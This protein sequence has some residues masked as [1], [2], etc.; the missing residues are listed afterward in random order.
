MD[1]TPSSVPCGRGR[2]REETRGR[3]EGAGP[4]TPLRRPGRARPRGHREREERRARVA[5]A[6]AAGTRGAGLLGAGASSRGTALGVTCWPLPAREEN[7]VAVR[8][9]PEPGLGAVA[10]SPALQRGWG[11]FLHAGAEARTPD[12]R[13]FLLR[14]PPGPGGRR[15]GRCSRGGAGRGACGRGR[16]RGFLW[17]GQLPEGRGRR[18]VP[19]GWAG[20][21]RWATWTR[22]SWRSARWK[23][24]SWVGPAEAPPTRAASLLRRAA[25]DSALQ[26]PSPGADFS[27]L[28]GRH[29]GRPA[30]FWKPCQRQRRVREATS[31][32]V[33]AEEV[34]QLITNLKRG[35]R[36]R[37][38]LTDQG[39]EVRIDAEKSAGPPG[40]PSTSLPA[41]GVHRQAGKVGSGRFGTSRAS[42]PP[43]ARWDSSWPGPLFAAFPG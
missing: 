26:A 33:S 17:A 5:E 16:R 23:D 43:P 15:Q 34:T 24:G 25:P 13:V 27:P 20:P 28:P 2:G 3:P 19:R 18:E 11:R 22:Q 7:V 36:C 37:K 10:G 35:K 41:F 12:P 6:G 14:G 29:P 38:G 42:Q 31:Q 21:G 4:G 8:G 39:A 9:A 30:F 1:P 32:V 40:L